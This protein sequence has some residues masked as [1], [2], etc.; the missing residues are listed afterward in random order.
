MGKS[1]EVIS[2][3]TLYKSYSVMRVFGLRG[4]GRHVAG[5]HLGVSFPSVISLGGSSGVCFTLVL[6]SCAPS[7]LL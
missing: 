6:E 7:Q 3:V 4:F 1:I 5:W 2:Q